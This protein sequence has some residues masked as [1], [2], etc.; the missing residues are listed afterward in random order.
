[1]SLSIGGLFTALVFLLVIGI[2]A[3]LAFYI[4]SRF[5]PAEP[6]GRIFE[7]VIVVV[8][9]LALMGVL[10]SLAGVVGPIRVTG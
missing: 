2:L 8:V 3:W 6:L 7:V 9:V 4:L 10:L 1:M 5:R